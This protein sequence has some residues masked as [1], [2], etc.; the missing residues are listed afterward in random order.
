[1]FFILF[2]IFGSLFILNL[3]VGVVTDQFNKEKEKLGKNCLLTNKQQEWVL[4]Q[5]LCVNSRPMKQRKMTKHKMINICIKI[6]TH[7]AFDTFILVLIMINTIILTLKWYGEPESM[8]TYL[9][10]FN[11]LFAGI[12]TLEAIIKILAF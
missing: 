2:F 8:G 6:S 7:P 9:E 3:F 4:I 10:V 11:Y 1:M 12:F 5:L